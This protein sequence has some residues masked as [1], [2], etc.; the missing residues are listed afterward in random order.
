MLVFG[1]T[2]LGLQDT[3]PMLKDKFREE[4]LGALTTLLASPSYFS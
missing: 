2:L 1:L 4:E 3:W